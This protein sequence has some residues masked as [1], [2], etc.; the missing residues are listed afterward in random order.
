MLPPP[1]ELRQ[2]DRSFCPER[3]PIEQDHP[4]ATLTALISRFFRKHLSRVSTSREWFAEIDGLRFVAILVVVIFHSNKHFFLDPSEE[5]PGWNVVSAL[6]Q[7]GWFGVQMF[8]VI[9]GF[10][11]ALPF[12]RQH[13]VQNRAVVLKDYYFRRLTRL[14]PPYIINLVVLFLFYTSLAPDHWD[15]VR[16]QVPHFLVSA[17]YTHRFFYGEWSSINHVAWSLEIEAQF[18]VLAPLLCQVFRIPSVWHRRLLL[19]ALIVAGCAIRHQNPEIIGKHFPGQMGFFFV[20][21]LFADIFII[22]W[23]QARSAGAWWWDIVAVTAWVSIFTLLG[24]YWFMVYLMPWLVLIAYAGS[25][26]GPLCRRLLTNLWIATFG[27]MC[28]T[29]YLYHISI[30]GMTLGLL[31]PLQ[32]GSV[33]IPFQ[34]LLSLGFIFALSAVL[35]VAFERPFMRPRKTSNLSK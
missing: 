9:S 12:A 17:T 20:G 18:Y 29:I 26:R 7:K 33:W 27:G 13:L 21:F 34:L 32:P 11:L 5:M 35:F 23:K 15:Y 30:M 14:E 31:G 28:Y 25:I 19:T 24:K 16:E 8:F 6:S 2:S 4:F 10:I 3:F 22:N 1:T